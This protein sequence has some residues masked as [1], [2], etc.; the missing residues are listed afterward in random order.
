MTRRRWVT[1]L[2]VVGLAVIAL[3]AAV[4]GIRG[5]E[6]R[7]SGPAAE[8]VVPGGAD[9]VALAIRQLRE[10]GVSGVLTYS[11]GNCRLQAVSL[12]ELEPARAPAYEMCRPASANG[13]IVAFD[14]DVVWTA[15]GYRTAHVVLSKKKLSRGIRAGLGIPAGEG[16]AGFRAVQATFLGQGRYVVLADSTYEPR[17]RVLALVAGGRVVFVQPR[18]VIRDARFLRPSPRGAYFVGFAAEGLLWFDRNADPR[19]FPAAVRGPHAVTWS[20]DER[21]T[22]LA[23]AESVYVFRSERPSERIVRIP[24]SVRDLHW[25]A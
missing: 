6:E 17:E 25:G 10:A 16:G 18:W 9:Q 11:D 4:D 14:G 21:W 2:V 12:P 13:G 8:P 22:A 5:R 7:A 23:T 1:G 20:P 19:A 24:L 3:A 15:L